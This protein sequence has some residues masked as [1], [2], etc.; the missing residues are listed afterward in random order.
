MSDKQPDR[1]RLGTEETPH[2]RARDSRTRG[3]YVAP[4]NLGDRTCNPTETRARRV[5][6]PRAVRV[7]FPRI[8]PMTAKEASQ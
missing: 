8:E 2:G 4:D 6:S 5:P 3:I 1:G 7:P